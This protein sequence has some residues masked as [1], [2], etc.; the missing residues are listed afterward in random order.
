MI[1]LY[2]AMDFL[3]LGAEIEQ[4]TTFVATWYFLRLGEKLIG[5]VWPQTFHALK[6]R[7]VLECFKDVDNTPGDWLNMSKYY[8]IKEVKK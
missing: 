5:Q 8:K 3:K 1:S 4:N 6:K 2:K 7:N